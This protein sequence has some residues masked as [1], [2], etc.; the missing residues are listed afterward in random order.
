[1]SKQFTA[2]AI[3]ML[4]EEGK[5]A[6]DN[7]V[8]RYIPELQ[9][10][11]GGV[12]LRHL[13]NHTSGIPAVTDLGL[14][15]PGITNAEL[16]RGLERQDSLVS[17]PG[18]TYR[19]SN[20]GYVLLAVIIERITGR[21]IGDFLS[22][23]I[24]TPLGMRA[25]FVQDGRQ[26]LQDV[27]LGYDDFGRQIPYTDVTTG[28]GGVFSNVDDLLKWDRA[29]SGNQL[30]ASATLSAA[31]EPPRLANVTSSTYGFGWNVTRDSG[32]TVQWHTGN[33]G[34]YRAYI[35]RRPADGLAIFM[36]TNHGSTNRVSI[37][38][39]IVNVLRNRRYE[40]PKRSIVTPMFRAV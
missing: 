14:D 31:F 10:Y 27:A 39:A 19:Y 9:L 6:Y 30:V 5:L 17:K 26:K 35:E 12:T 28:S 16:L 22:A 11:A 15:R 23:R 21:P 34:S 33:A 1:V 24:F 37:A 2:M 25:T 8:T 29:L 38:R 36:L 18:T 32:E 20:P 13:L 4:A 3:M 40:L 7:T